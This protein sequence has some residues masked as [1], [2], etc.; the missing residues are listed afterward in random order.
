[1]AYKLKQ[2]ITVMKTLKYKLAMELLIIKEIGIN[3]IEA[4]KYR[5][6]DLYIILG[7]NFN[8]YLI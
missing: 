5:I 8:L 7:L 1:M 6:T 3:N 2:L 4:T